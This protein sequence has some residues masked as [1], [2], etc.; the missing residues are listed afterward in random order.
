MQEAPGGRKGK[1]F[2]PTT[3]RLAI[4]EK[5]LEQRGRA[6]DARTEEEEAKSGQRSL[7]S[8][9][10][11]PASATGHAR[12]SSPPRRSSNCEVSSLLP[13]KV[14][15]YA[16]RSNDAATFSSQCSVARPI[17][18]TNGA[19][20][21]TGT[22]TSLRR[23]AGPTGQTSLL[24]MAGSGKLLSNISNPKSC[25]STISTGPPYLT[26]GPGT[27]PFESLH[28]FEKCVALWGGATKT[29][30]SLA[31]VRA[32]LTRPAL[33]V[34]LN[35]TL[36]PG[37]L[38]LGAD[39][40]LFQASLLPYFKIQPTPIPLPNNFTG[41]VDAQKNPIPILGQRPERSLLF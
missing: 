6:S 14:P 29:C 30:I 9:P 24:R 26:H 13:G 7:H 35:G 4:D 22:H 8:S 3:P 21:P 20:G 5:V 40:C 10:S 37:L 23:M 12:S 1:H 19:P 27:P 11:E 16:C 31:Q 25:C 34:N 39:V 41:V 36:T 2:P 38:D 32:S 17:S 18:C 15:G 33:G 28:P